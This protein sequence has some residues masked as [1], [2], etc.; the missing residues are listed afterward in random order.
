MGNLLFSPSGRIGPSAYFKGIIIM[1]VINVVLT[2]LPL[3]SPMLSMLGIIMLVTFYMFIA[4]GIKRSHDAG[5]SGWM[6]LTHILLWIGVSSVG[7]YIL[8]MMTG[9]SVADSFSAAFSGD[10]EAMEAATAAMEAPTYV[11]MSTVIGIVTTLVSAFLINMFNKQDSGDNQYG[12][13]P[14]A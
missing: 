6:V 10:T 12:P 8:A 1:M 5:K 13:V 4:L 2:L 14:T 9:I 7:G 3:I 11:M